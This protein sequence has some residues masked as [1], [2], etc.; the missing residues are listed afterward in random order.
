VLRR[1]LL[2]GAGLAPL[3]PSLSARALAQTMEEPE[4]EATDPELG[5]VHVPPTATVG[6]GGLVEHHDEGLHLPRAVRIERGGQVEALGDDA[7]GLP[8]GGIIPVSHKAATPT[9]TELRQALRLVNNERARTG[10]APLTLDSRLSRAAQG[11]AR[12]MNDARVLSHTG[13]GGSTFVRRIEA[14]GYEPWRYLGE[15]VAR[16]YGTWSGAMTG[17]M[18]SSGHRANILGRNFRNV[19]LGRYNHY[20][21]QEFGAQ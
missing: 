20:Y 5:E 14:A 9:G 12:Y 2:I 8:E 19:G 3:L 7:Y 21:V 18:G 1:R 6:R 16:G 17:W 11:H 10:R 4:A 13:R 15:N